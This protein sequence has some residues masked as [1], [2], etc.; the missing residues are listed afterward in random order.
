[1]KLLIDYEVLL[2]MLEGLDRGDYRFADMTDNGGCVN[3][4]LDTYQEKAETSLTPCETFD[5]V[6]MNGS[7]CLESIL[8][9]NFGCKKPFL[10]RKRLTGVWHDGQKDYTDMTV[11]GSE[12]YSKLVDTLYGLETIGVIDN[13]NDIIER[14]DEIASGREC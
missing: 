14:L 10:K 2:D 5:L 4:Y 1:M 9:L 8:Q 12:A 13:A 11:K 3:V 7:R 6:K